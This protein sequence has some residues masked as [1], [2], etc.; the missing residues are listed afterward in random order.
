[1]LVRTER[2]NGFWSA[3]FNQVKKIHQSWSPLPESW[4]RLPIRTPPTS[5]VQQ[6]KSPWSSSASL[7]VTFTRGN[8]DTTLVTAKI[9]T[10]RKDNYNEWL[11]GVD[12]AYGENSRIESTES[13][14]GFGQWNHLFS[15]K[16]FG[17]ARLEGLHD[18]IA[19]IK[20]RVTIGPGAGYYFLKETNTA[21]SAEA[22]GA[23]IFE[24]LGTMDNSYASL[25]LAEHFEHKFSAHGARIWQPVEF[26]PE[27]DLLYN[28]IINAEIG[29]EAGI[30]KN[31]G[32]KV[33]LMI[34]TTASP[35]P[36]G[37][38]TT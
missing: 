8:S 30:A 13:L 34:P 38:T 2:Q 18:G 27:V 12:G 28:Y 33:T 35:R 17:Y 4:W 31:R 3:I 37:S 14:H 25:R 24:R 16:F 5:L 10:D 7:G 11:F 36:D 26:L 20:Y 29:I 9:L 15:E 19:D 32:C 6:K 21:L 23:A 1:M 22:G